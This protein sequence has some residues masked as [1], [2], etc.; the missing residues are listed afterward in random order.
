MSASSV[1][2]S[3]QGG[4]ITVPV[5][6]VQ[7]H[8]GDAKN[9]Q[10]GKQKSECQTHLAHGF[11]SSRLSHMALLLKRV[12]CF[13]FQHSSLSKQTAKAEQQ[14]NQYKAAAEASSIGVLGSTRAK[15]TA[16][17]TAEVLTP[18]SASSKSKKR[19]VKI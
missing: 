17:A 12:F 6:W 1:L 18:L 3:R 13:P 16:A 19:L 10:E 5:P 15:S 7:G 8:V 9:V 14:N 2:L 4:T 11:L